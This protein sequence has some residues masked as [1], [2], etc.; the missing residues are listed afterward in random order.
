MTML[1]FYKSLDPDQKRDIA[2]QAETSVA[3]LS[4]IAHGWRR[5]GPDM[6]LRIERATKKQVTRKA[7]R[8]DIWG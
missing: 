7:L 2:K 6:A 5:A 4:H 3:Y 1:E 8:P